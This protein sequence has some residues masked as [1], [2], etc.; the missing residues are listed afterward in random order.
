MDM[1]QLFGLVEG[2]FVLMYGTCCS[3]EDWESWDEQQLVQLMGKFD[4]VFAK[5]VL[6]K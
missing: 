4:T 6:L 2:D 5:R 1:F 3:W